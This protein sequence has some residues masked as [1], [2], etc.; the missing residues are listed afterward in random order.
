V[1]LDFGPAREFGIVA[2]LWDL[3]AV[4]GVHALARVP[5]KRPLPI[6]NCVPI[7][8]HSQSE[9]SV[10]ILSISPSLVFDR[11]NDKCSIALN[12]THPNDAL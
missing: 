10:T 2:M 1:Q 8:G 6:P 5:Q 11:P 3:C 9:E 12:S 7:G 4:A